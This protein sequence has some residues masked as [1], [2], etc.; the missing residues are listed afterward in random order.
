[1]KET[2]RCIFVVDAKEILAEVI[3]IVMIQEEGL[4]G[5]E[6]DLDLEWIRTVYIL[7]N[8]ARKLAKLIK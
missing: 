3:L 6:K 7:A 4:K 1:M 2:R 5:I 8:V